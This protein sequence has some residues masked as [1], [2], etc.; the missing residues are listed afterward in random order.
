[1]WTGM[2]L[3][4][5]LKHCAAEIR[6]WEHLRWTHVTPRPTTAWGPTLAQR[7]FGGVE[8]QAIFS[9][10]CS[11][12]LLYSGH[13]AKVRCSQNGQLLQC[14]F[15]AALLFYYSFTLQKTKSYSVCSRDSSSRT[16]LVNPQTFVLAVELLNPSSLNISVLIFIIFITT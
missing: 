7:L 3:W 9:I 6:W 2:S 8:R 1:M 13:Q 5:S 10:T 16:D 11:Q 15:A 14:R 4:L 12:E